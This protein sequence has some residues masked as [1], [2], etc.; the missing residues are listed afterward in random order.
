M[1]IA[2]HI[3]DT[4]FSLRRVKK[5]ELL[6]TCISLLNSDATRNPPLVLGVA[7]DSKKHS[8]DSQIHIRGEN[9]FGDL[10]QNLTPAEK[11]GS[12]TDSFQ[13][14]VCS[15]WVFEKNE[16]QTVAGTPGAPGAPGTTGTP[17][18]ASG[19]GTLGDRERG[20]RGALGGERASDPRDAAVV[21]N[22]G[23]ISRKAGRKRWF[24]AFGENINHCSGND[25]TSNWEILLSELEIIRRLEP[26]S[27]VILRGIKPGC[28]YPHLLLSPGPQRWPCQRLGLEAIA[29]HCRRRKLGLWRWKRDL[30]R[31][32]S[33]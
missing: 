12:K 16:M 23:R 7:G 4:N 18:T 22:D 13:F 30:L 2:S 10:S 1:W 29:G 31:I 6:R 11:G 33:V 20:R 25:R 28:R 24:E 5:L 17:G 15:I 32:I 9:Y 21:H 3:V 19:L 14:P 27:T 8:G 26:H